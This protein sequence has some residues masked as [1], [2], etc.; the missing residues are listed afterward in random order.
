MNTIGWLLILGGFLLGRAVIR[1][2]VMNLGEDLSDA[3]LAIV[4]GD[5]K[6]FTAVLNR[7]GEGFIPEVGVTGDA[8][9]GAAANGAWAITGQIKYKLGNVKPH[10]AAA[11]SKYGPQFGITDIGGYRAVGSVPGS[12]HPKGLALDFMIDAKKDKARGDALAAALLQDPQVKY[13]IWDKRI[14]DRRNS[15]GW[16]PYSGPSDHTDHVHASFLSAE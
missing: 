13:V 7:T 12:D 3:L 9:G 2:R 16:Q 15:K 10:V 11:A 5:T 1:G 8:V 4:R 6:E 14:N